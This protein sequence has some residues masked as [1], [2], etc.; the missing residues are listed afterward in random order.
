MIRP[1]EEKIRM[2]LVEPVFVEGIGKVMTFGLGKHGEDNWKQF[3]HK[4]FKGAMYRHL[5]AYM[6]GEVLDSETGLSHLYHL[7][8]DAMF[9]DYFDKKEERENRNDRI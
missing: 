2:D 7:S 8:C 9:C 3:S 6:K 5:I 1:G 4:E